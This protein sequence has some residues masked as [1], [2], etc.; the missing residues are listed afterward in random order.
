MLAAAE[1]K[2]FKSSGNLS[3]EKPRT[4]WKE[5]RHSLMPFQEVYIK[6]KGFGVGH[7]LFSL[8]CLL[9]SDRL[10]S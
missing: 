9:V 2:G 10:T 6:A 3:K 8:V 4:V 1:A 7:L 5:H